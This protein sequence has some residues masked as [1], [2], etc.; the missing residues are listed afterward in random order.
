MAWSGG[1]FTRTDGTR[2]GSTIWAQAKAAS[3]KIVSSDHDTHDQ[4][5]SDGI[6]ACLHK[7]GQNTPTANMPWGGFKITGLA[8]GSLAGHSVRY[9]QVGLLSAANA[10]TGV[11]TYSATQRW[12][13][14][15]DLTSANPLVIGTDGNMFDV[16]GTTNF[17]SMTVTAGTWFILQFDAA[18]TMTHGAGTL[19]LPW[20]ANIT[21]AT[22]GM[23]LCVA[24]ADDVVRVVSYITATKAQMRTLLGLGSMAVEATSAVP[25]M[26]YAGTQSFADQILSRPQIEDYGETVNALGAL[27]GGT[28]DID[29]VSG[30]VVTATVDTSEETFTFS[31]P[32]G[33]GK[34]G[35]FTLILTNGGSQTVNWP[36]SVDWVGGTA[37]SLTSS[38]VDVLVFITTDG[39]TVWL[40]FL[41]G[42]DVK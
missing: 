2:T 26:T 15:G 38:G 8:A 17:A 9:E 31:N 40:G 12:S 29:L 11:N 1:S 20:G 18:L 35:S 37:P 39:G 6:N 14:G 5:L 10:F 7:A 28:D 34:A 3:V 41:T 16:G 22:G 13:K 4:D 30:N 24:T 21:T 23:A 25:A 36:A 27:G 42:L 19:D 33:S 32:P